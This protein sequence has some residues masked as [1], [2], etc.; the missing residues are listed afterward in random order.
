M[1]RAIRIIVLT[2]AALVGLQGCRSCSDPQAEQNLRRLVW[3]KYAHV[4]NVEE[5]DAPGPTGTVKLAPTSEGFW[6]VFDICTVDVQG[7]ALT[8]FDYDAGNFFV[9]AGP[10]SYGPMNPGT[11][12]TGGI[13]RSGYDPVVTGLVHRGLKLSP[14]TD[15]FP[16]AYHPNVRYRV[17]VY[18]KERP[19]NYR[20]EPLALKYA[21]HPTMM[22]DVSPGGPSVRDFYNDGAS[23]PIVGTCPPPP[24]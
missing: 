20:N 6:A 2:T 11:V 5:M 4:A 19:A 1:K 16:K 13:P 21:N 14:V 24:P 17:A 12:N 22:Q 9:E 15:N 3:M 23:P 8:G 10:A 18:V 7:S